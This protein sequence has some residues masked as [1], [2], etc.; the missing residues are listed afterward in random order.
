MA[1]AMAPT[2]DGTFV[3]ETSRLAVEL[4]AAFRPGRRCDCCGSADSRR[5][6]SNGQAFPTNHSPMKRQSRTRTFVD[7]KNAKYQH[8]LNFPMSQPRS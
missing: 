8:H 2:S 6:T 1:I 5:Q 3:L 4:P 7:D